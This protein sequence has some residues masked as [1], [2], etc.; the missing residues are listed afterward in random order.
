M[1]YVNP[2]PVLMVVLEKDMIS[3]PEEQLLLFKSFL[4]PKIV[5]V[6]LG[7]GHLNVLSGAKFPMLAK[8][9]NGFVFSLRDDKTSCI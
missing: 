9:Q 5:H 7:K 6:A 4:E 3:P 1:D 8:M 2:I